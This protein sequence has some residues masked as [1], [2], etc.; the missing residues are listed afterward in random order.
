MLY[1]HREQEA[2]RGLEDIQEELRW[3]STLATS[4]ILALA[5]DHTG[6]RCACVF[7]DKV[8]IYSISTLLVVEQSVDLPPSVQV[9]KALDTK[10]VWSLC[11]QYL[12]LHLTSLPDLQSI[13]S[14]TSITGASL[15]LVWNVLPGLLLNEIRCDSTISFLLSLLSDFLLSSTHLG[16]NRP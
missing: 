5:L 6:D 10:V 1:S 11:G 12:S 4:P 13:H 7:A 9:L 15:V 3:S 8:L 14:T 16:Y 2:F